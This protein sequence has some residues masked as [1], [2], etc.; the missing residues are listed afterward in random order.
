MLEQLYQLIERH[1]ALSRQD[2]ALFAQAFE[3]ITVSTG[4]TLEQFGKTPYHLYLVN[5]GIVRSFYYD[6]KGHEANTQLAGN[7][8]WITSFLDFVHQLPAREEI[9][10][11]TDSH[12]LRIAHPNM[13]QLIDQNERFRTFSLVIFEQAIQNAQTRANDLANLTAEQR[14]RKWLK[15]SA[16]W[17]STVPV[18]HV[19][20][21]LGIKPESLSRIRKKI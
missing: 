17:I 20:S 4:T 13:R 19:A 10:S 9:Q 15:H 21:Y 8:Q 3:P 16:D 18:R 6:T 1:I 11:L 5:Q 12:L 14:Y 2:K 7:G